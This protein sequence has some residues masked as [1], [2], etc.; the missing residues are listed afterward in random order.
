MRDPGGRALIR[1][2]PDLPDV[3]ASTKI[4]TLDSWPREFTYVGLPWILGLTIT[5]T[6]LMR[7]VMFGPVVW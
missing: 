5:G 1:A 7:G 4:F 6:A 2:H 3:P